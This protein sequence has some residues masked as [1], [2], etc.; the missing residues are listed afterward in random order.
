MAPHDPIPAGD[1][2]HVTM[3]VLQTSD[4]LQGRCVVGA[5]LQRPGVHSP[6]S[7]VLTLILRSASL[8][9]PELGGPCGDAA[10]RGGDP[11]AL[12]RLGGCATIVVIRLMMGPAFLGLLARAVRFSTTTEHERRQQQHADAGPK[13]GSTGHQDAPRAR[14]SSVTDR[15]SGYGSRPRIRGAMTDSTKRDW[16]TAACPPVQSYPM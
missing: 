7:I 11:I 9:G 13:W 16:V 10:N 8:G 6:R 15:L 2:D 12:R 1:C 3:S 14:R 4:M 5:D